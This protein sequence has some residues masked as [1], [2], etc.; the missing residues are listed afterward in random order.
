VKRLPF[1]FLI[2]IVASCSSKSSDRISHRFR[3]KSLDFLVKAKLAHP[4]MGSLGNLDEAGKKAFRE[5]LDSFAG[6]PAPANKKEEE[7]Y[8][9]AQ[10]INHSISEAYQILLIAQ[11][12]Y[13]DETAEIIAGNKELERE[14]EKKWKSLA[15]EGKRV[16]DASVDLEK[17]IQSSR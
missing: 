12:R 16:L 8:A 9:K 3:E 13:E 11:T 1:V 10:E 6:I 15:T 7:L 4:F 14:R 5:A 17:E 2:L